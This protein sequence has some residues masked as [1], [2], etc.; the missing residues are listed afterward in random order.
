MMSGV[1]AT[2]ICQICAVQNNLLVHFAVAACSVA[3]QCYI[4]TLDDR[5]AIRYAAKSVHYM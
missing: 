5:P 1:K 3:V 4:E 2:S